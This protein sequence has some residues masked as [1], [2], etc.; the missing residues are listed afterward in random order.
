MISP[1]RIRSISSTRRSPTAAR[2][3]GGSVIR[4]RR[5]RDERGRSSCAGAEEADGQGACLGV[6]ACPGQRLDDAL[7]E[8]MD[9]EDV[10]PVSGLGL[11]QEVEEQRRKAAPLRFPGANRVPGSVPAAAGA[12]GKNDESARI[13]RT[14]EFAFEPCLPMVTS[15]RI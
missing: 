1:R 8:K 6:V 12:M 13:G 7:G 2:N 11:G 9:V 15:R 10:A 3:R 5:R 4:R 14:R